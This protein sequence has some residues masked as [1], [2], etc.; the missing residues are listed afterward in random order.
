[1]TTE[2]QQIVA[3]AVDAE[4]DPPP[5]RQP[6]PDIDIGPELDDGWRQTATL[7]PLDRTKT[8]KLLRMMVAGGTP[9]ERENA[10]RIIHE[11]DPYLNLMEI[12]E[13]DLPNQGWWLIQQLT[14]MSNQFYAEAERLREQLKR[15]LNEDRVHDLETRVQ[16][17]QATI[18]RLNMLYEAYKSQTKLVEAQRDGWKQ[19]AEV[20]EEELRNLR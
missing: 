19:R 7:E 10:R 20:A 13:N 1:L 9:G 5:E 11:R 16:K 2:Q 18:R 14:D 4:D 6:R 8:L 15:A 3:A 12:N 17:Q